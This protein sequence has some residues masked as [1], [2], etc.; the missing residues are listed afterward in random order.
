MPDGQAWERCRDNQ[1]VAREMFR[2][3]PTPAV[4]S[5]TIENC[6]TIFK[7]LQ[8]SKNIKGPLEGEMKKAVASIMAAT[9]V[10]HDRTVS[11]SPSNAEAEELRHQLELLKAEREK[12]T[13]ELKKQMAELADQVKVLTNQLSIRLIEEGS[14]TK[15]EKEKGGRNL[16]GR[17]RIESDRD[18]DSDSGEWHSLRLRTPQNVSPKKTALRRGG[19]SPAC[20]SPGLAGDP[21]MKVEPQ[22]ASVTEAQGPLL[23]GSP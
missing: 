10:L 8:V 19:L 14:I 6:V 2:H 23:S 3:S 20:V 5:D 9:A 12:E 17:N 7:S 1:R 13:S 15:S 18:S 11:S 21:C 16:R 4:V 22:A